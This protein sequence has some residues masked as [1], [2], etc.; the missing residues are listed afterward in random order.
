MVDPV[1]SHAGA[2]SMVPAL[3]SE[4]GVCPL[5]FAAEATKMSRFAGGVALSP[6]SNAMCVPSGDQ[7]GR[8]SFVPGERVRFFGFVALS[9]C[10][11]S[12][13]KMSY[14]FDAETPRAKA[15]LVRSGDHF[16]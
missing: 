5:P 8:S 3:V 9:G 4:T 7:A 15:I 2:P 16:G 12:C 6:F 13:T 11:R 1:G 14:V 10:V